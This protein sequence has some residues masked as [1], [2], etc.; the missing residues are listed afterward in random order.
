MGTEATY[1]VLDGL[2]ASST[3]AL[4]PLQKLIAPHV[5]EFVV[6]WWGIWILVLIYLVGKHLLWPFIRSKNR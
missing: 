5:S 6:L 3:I 1:I 2:D 4:H